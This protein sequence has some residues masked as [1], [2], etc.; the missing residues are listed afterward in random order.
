MHNDDVRIEPI[1]GEE[2]LWRLV[3]ALAAALTPFE[4]AEA[5]TKLGAAAAGGSFTNMA[6]L[7]KEPDSVQVV[8]RPSFSPTVLTRRGTYD[9]DADT[10]ACEAIRVGLPVLLGSL[11]E[12]RTRY[13]ALLAEIEEAGLGSRAS[14]PLHSATG[15]TFGAIG[16]G[17]PG[18]QEFEA[19]QLRRLDLIAQLVG[20]ALERAMKQ[21]TE[22]GQGDQ[23]P[24]ILETM[25]NAFFSLDAN[26]TIT[27]L[28][29]EAERLLR[30]WRAD[31]LGSPFLSA[32]PGAASARL[33]RSF[34][35]AIE[36]GESVVFEEFFAPFDGWFE[37]HAW[38]DREGL[39]VYFSDVSE[40]RNS[41]F[42]QSV[43]LDEARRAQPGDFRGRRLDPAHGAATR[44]RALR[45]AEPGGHHLY[46]RLVHCRG[47]IGR[48]TDSGGGRSSRPHPRW[49]GQTPGRRVPTPSRVHR[50]ASWSTG[51]ASHCD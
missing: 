42:A 5:F 43:A 28:N 12:I 14:L 33:G 10:P 11:D 36:S 1:T 15:T 49:S 41:E 21:Q 45:T 18:P 32:S 44:N 2:S 16:F 39:N 31:V 34:R 48:G 6:M 29:A 24:S 47:S 20:L 25:P 50:P 9:L 35:H 30:D 13:P 40:R 4:V 3:T 37:V 22:S 38:P 8:H 17:W 46:G 7:T 23:L 19:L 27:S 26:L 51:A